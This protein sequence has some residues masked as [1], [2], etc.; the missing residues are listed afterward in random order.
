M[1]RME[2]IG[3][4]MAPKI[5]PIPSADGLFDLGIIYATGRDGTPD[6]VEAHKWFNLAAV[7]GNS[8]AAEHRQEIA[9]EMSAADIAE[10][11]RA[12]REWLRTH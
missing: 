12:A 11:Q 3:A 7:K 5:E 8:E 6:L 9:R 4:E 2:M 1:A 10:A